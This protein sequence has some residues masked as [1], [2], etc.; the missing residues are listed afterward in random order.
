MTG[1]TSEGMCGNQDH[2]DSDFLLTARHFKLYIPRRNNIKNPPLLLLHDNEDYVASFFVEEDEDF[3]GYV[4][5][6][7]AEVKTKYY[8]SLVHATR[9]YDD[10]CYLTNSR[11]MKLLYQLHAEA[12]QGNIKLEINQT[13]EL[14]E[15]RV[16]HIQTTL[17]TN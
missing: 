10:K 12:W 5:L 11:I 8:V 1:S 16:I 6:S 15:K 13:L 7:L 14:C 9:M 4:K 2:H 17:K 3:Q